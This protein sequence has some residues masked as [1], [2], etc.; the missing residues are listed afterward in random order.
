MKN[1]EPSFFRKLNDFF[2]IGFIIVLIAL[3]GLIRKIFPPDPAIASSGA[4]LDLFFNLLLSFCLFGYY[5]KK[6]N[7]NLVRQLIMIFFFLELIVGI[8]L[9]KHLVAHSNEIVFI[10]FIGIPCYVG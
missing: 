9:K 6:Y 4:G 3:Q 10:G 2:Y 7:P 8:F 1:T 5:I